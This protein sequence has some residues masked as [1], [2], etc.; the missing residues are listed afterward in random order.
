MNM[1]P[2]ALCFLVSMVTGS[3]L[4]PPFCQHM[5]SK[6]GENFVLV[7]MHVATAEIRGSSTGAEFFLVSFI[8]HQYSRKLKK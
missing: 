2:Y 5:Y 8:V 1:L 6:Q 3:S 4:L 7:Y